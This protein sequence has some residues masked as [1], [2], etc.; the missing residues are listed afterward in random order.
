MF[1]I[2][3][4]GYVL[5]S[6]FSSAIPLRFPGELLLETCNDYPETIQMCTV[7]EVS[8]VFC[9]PFHLQLVSTRCYRHRNV[10]VNEKLCR[11]S[12]ILS[13]LVGWWRPC[14]QGSLGLLLGSDYKD[15]MWVNGNNAVTSHIPHAYKGCAF[16]LENI[17]TQEMDTRN[18]CT[19]LILTASCLRVKSK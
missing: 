15:E 17:K 14:F 12:R 7:G 8:C 10:A 4:E 13:T 1:K 11:H 3:F 19:G 9:G 18:L 6:R 5:H 16:Y 2:S